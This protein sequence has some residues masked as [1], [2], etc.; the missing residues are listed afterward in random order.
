MSAANATS[1][2]LEAAQQQVDAAYALHD[3]YDFGP[4][5]RKRKMTA[6]RDAALAKVAECEAAEEAAEEDGDRRALHARGLCGA[7]AYLIHALCLL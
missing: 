3:S 7:R 6:A 4:D 5:E 2:L 1:A